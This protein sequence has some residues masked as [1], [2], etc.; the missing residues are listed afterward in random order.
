MKKCLSML[1]LAAMLLSAAACSSA[2][3]PKTASTDPVET[4]DTAVIDTV[5]EAETALSDQLPDTK[6]GGRTYRIA[7]D[8][9]YE[10]ELMAEEQTGETENDA[11][12][13]R[14]DRIQERFDIAIELTVM[15]EKV[16]QNYKKLVQHAQAGDDFCD[17]AVQEV[18]ELNIATAA[19]IF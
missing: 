16:A 7:G 9:S 5:A 18:W 19:G 2:G 15:T 3:D 4:A 12:Y 1:L 17:V 13:H 11:I 8:D 14:N 6:F 10:A